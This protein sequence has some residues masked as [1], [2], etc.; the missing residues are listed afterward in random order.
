MR[1]VTLLAVLLSIAPF[2]RAFA[3][4]LVVDLSG[5]AGTHS[6]LQDAVDAA[7]DGDLILVRPGDYRF[8]QTVSTIVTAKSLTIVADPPGSAPVLTGIRISAIASPR[9]VV[10]RGL[11]LLPGILPV[12]PGT[13]VTQSTG[14][15]WFEDCTLAGIPG[16]GSLGQNFPGE[17][18]L[19]VN[20]AQVTLVRCQVTGGVGAVGTFTIPA[21]DGGPGQRLGANA[22]VAVHDS[23]ISGGDGGLGTF[24]GNGGAGTQAVTARVFLSGATV[25]GGAPGGAPAQGGAGLVA[26]ATSGVSLLQTTVTGGAGAPDVQAPPGVVQRLPGLA[27]SI[28][29]TSPVTPG[30]QA[31]LS[32]RGEPGDLAFL[33]WSVGTSHLPIPPITGW[34]LLGFPVFGPVVLG[35]L[36]PPS[37]DL[38]LNFTALPLVPPT[39]GRTDLAQAIFLG[40]DAALVAGSPTAFVRRV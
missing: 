15:V 31:T 39:V 27:R 8:V 36:P 23:T 32:I 24:P 12:S 13:E 25:T 5:G 22:S 33:F 20:G 29:V 28:E 17:P 30:T 10:I 11:Q 19:R 35:P 3:A 14:G 9:K 38:V 18:G 2:P 34:L 40:L 37:G 4:N 16:L 7:Q 1:R 21:S 26:D 6:T